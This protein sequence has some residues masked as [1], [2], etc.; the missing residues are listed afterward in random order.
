MLLPGSGVLSPWV[1][2]GGLLMDSAIGFWS[3]DQSVFALHLTG[4]TK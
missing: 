3:S 2:A 4:N 1:R